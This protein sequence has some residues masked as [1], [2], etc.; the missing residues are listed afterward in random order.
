[1]PHF[2]QAEQKWNVLLVPAVVVC[3]YENRPRRIFEKKG[4]RREQII[5]IL[6]NGCS[7]M[8]V[9]QNDENTRQMEMGR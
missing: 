9:S 6:P 8:S 5:K 4:H 2:F 7:G 3:G 1:L